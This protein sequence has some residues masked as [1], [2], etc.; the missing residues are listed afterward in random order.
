L[1]VLKS[2]IIPSALVKFHSTWNEPQPVDFIFKSM[3]ATHFVFK[4]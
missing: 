3:K 2:V 1:T 4:Y